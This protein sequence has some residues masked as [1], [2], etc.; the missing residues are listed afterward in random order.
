MGIFLT[1]KGYDYKWE[2]MV[3]A[4]NRGSEFFP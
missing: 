4:R 1:D 3:S 2:T